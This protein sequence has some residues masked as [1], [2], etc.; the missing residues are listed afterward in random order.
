MR[1]EARSSSKWGRRRAAGSG[2]RAFTDPTQIDDDHCPAVS[3]RLTGQLI[4]LSYIPSIRSE[5]MTPRA[6]FQEPVKLVG[7]K[8][9][10][11]QPRDHILCTDL[12]AS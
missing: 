10:K 6:H 11:L 3:Q 7:T 5:H 8:Q 12:L 2:Q 4:L 9:N 1:N